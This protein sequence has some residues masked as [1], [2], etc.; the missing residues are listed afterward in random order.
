MKKYVVAN[1]RVIKQKDAQAWFSEFATLILLL[2][3]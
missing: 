2:M 1:W 3:D